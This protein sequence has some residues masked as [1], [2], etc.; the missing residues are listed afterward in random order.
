MKK[1]IK[2]VLDNYKNAMNLYGEAL[3]KGRGYGCA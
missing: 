1:M 3:M 2:E